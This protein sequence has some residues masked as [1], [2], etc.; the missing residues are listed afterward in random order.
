MIPP[1]NFL[2]TTK[3]FTAKDAK[4]A[5]RGQKFCVKPN[6][7]LTYKPVNGIITAEY[8]EESKQNR[9]LQQYSVNPNAFLFAFF[10]FFAVNSGLF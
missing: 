2:H 6:R 4:D 9:W 1:R 10:A 8:A 7:D 3:L 5:K